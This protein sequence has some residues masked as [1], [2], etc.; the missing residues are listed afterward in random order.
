MIKY[1]DFENEIEKID[2][3]INNLNTKED[4]NINEIQKLNTERNEILKKIYAKLS[5]WQKVQVSRH[6]DRPH[7]LQYVNQIF[8]DIVFLHGDKKI[9]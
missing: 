2:I 5:P 9:R 1:F 8:K 4:A 6:N 3:L 7:T